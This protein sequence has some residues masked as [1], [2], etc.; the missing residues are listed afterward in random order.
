DARAGQRIP[1]RG[2]VHS[3]RQDP[4][5]PPEISPP[6]VLSLRRVQRRPVELVRAD[7]EMR[8][9]HAAQCRLPT[10]LGWTLGGSRVIRRPSRGLRVSVLVLTPTRGLR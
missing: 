7:G 1:V 9:A 8:G 6:S 5:G 10:K 2:T 4:P 3:Y